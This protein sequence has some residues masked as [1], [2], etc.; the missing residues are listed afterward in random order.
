MSSKI[1]NGETMRNMPKCRSWQIHGGFL[2]LE[3][4][5]TGQ[6]PQHAFDHETNELDVSTILLNERLHPLL[7]LPGSTSPVVEHPNRKPSIFQD[8]LLDFPLQIISY[9]WDDNDV[10]P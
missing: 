6:L 7:A 8:K 1:G 5:K 2:E 10:Q 9:N 3:L 4:E